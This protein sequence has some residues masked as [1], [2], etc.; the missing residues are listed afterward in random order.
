[1]ENSWKYLLYLIVTSVRVVIFADIFYM[2]HLNQ[3]DKKH[4]D[5]FFLS[6]L[7][8]YIQKLDTDKS[9]VWL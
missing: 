6:T 3:E 4:Q 1:M 8:F 9:M 5:F 7:L 2:F